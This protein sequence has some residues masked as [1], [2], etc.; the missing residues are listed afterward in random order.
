MKFQKKGNFIQRCYDPNERKPP[1][2][3]VLHFDNLELSDNKPRQ[4]NLSFKT[5]SVFDSFLHKS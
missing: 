3:V 4:P 2:M 5:L 1:A